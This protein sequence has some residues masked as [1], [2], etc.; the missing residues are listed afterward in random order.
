MSKETGGIANNLRYRKKKDKVKSCRYSGGV[1]PVT[2]VL[3]CR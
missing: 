1:D 3:A 2:K